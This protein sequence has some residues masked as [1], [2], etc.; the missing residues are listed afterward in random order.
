M[1]PKGLYLMAAVAL[2]GCSEMEEPI[3][4]D[5]DVPMKSVTLSANLD[6]TEPTK[7]SLDNTGLFAWQAG[8][9]ISVLSTDNKFYVFEI[10]DGAGTKTASFTGQIPETAEVSNVA[11]YPAIVSTGTDNVIISGNK[12]TFTMPETYEYVDDNTNV[13]MVANGDFVRS[14]MSFKQIGGAMRFP[15]NN[16]PRKAKFIFTSANKRITGDYSL[17]LSKIGESFIEC[18]DSAEGSSLTIN[19]SSEIDGKPASFNVPLPVGIYDDFTVSIQDESGKSLFSKEYRSDKNKIERKT[20]RLMKELQLDAIPVSVETVYPYFINARVLWHPQ[21]GAEGYALYVDDNE[22]IILP[23]LQVNSNGLMEYSFGNFEHGTEHNI[24]IAKI[25]GDGI[26]EKTKSARNAFKTGEIW[27]IRNNVGPTHICFEYTNIAGT[28]GSATSAYHVQVFDTEDTLKTPV[29]SFYTADL[30]VKKAGVY[31]GRQWYGKVN[32]NAS[33][34]PMRISVGNLQPGKDYYIRMKSVGSSEHKVSVGT[35]EGNTQKAITLYSKTGESKYSKLYKI[36]TE[37]SHSAETNEVLFEG[38]DDMALG[39]DYVNSSATLIPVMQAADK[40]YIA[41]LKKNY[42]AFLKNENKKWCV[43]TAQFNETG[44]FENYGF[45]S[46]GTITHEC[47]IKDWTYTGTCTPNYGFVVLGRNDIASLRTPALESA[48]LSETPVPCVVTLKACPVQYGPEAIFDNIRI[49]V[50]K[51]DASGNYIAASIGDTK[52]LTD[53]REYWYDTKNYKN[54]YSWQEISDVV[55]LAKGWKLQITIPNPSNGSNATLTGCIAIDDIH[56]VT[57]INLPPVSDSREESVADHTNYYS[58]G[59][60]FFPISYWWDVPAA[61][62]SKERYEEVKEA[63][64]NVVLHTGEI[65]RSFEANKQI[66]SWCQELGMK[67]I[68]Y[69]LGE[70]AA[71]RIQNT[72]ELKELYPDTYV[73]DYGWDE[74][75]SSLAAGINSFV[76]EYQSAMSDCQVY[77]NLFPSYARPYQTGVSDYSTYIDRFLSSGS[78]KSISVDTYPL[79]KNGG[80]RRDYFYNLDIVRAKALEKKI[81]FWVITQS[82]ASNDKKVTEPMIRWTVWV[83]LAFGSKGIAYFTYWQPI[84]YDNYKYMIA[85]DGTRNETYNWIKQMNSDVITIGKALMNCHADGVITTS[86]DYTLYERRFAYGPVSSVSA[87]S[88]A[89]VGCFTDVTTGA[90][91]VLVVNE[92]P[93]TESNTVSLSLDNTVPSVKITRNNETSV[94]SPS[95]GNL[96][97]SVSQGEGVLIEF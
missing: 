56:V 4:H 68:G 3:I 50:Y 87:T 85:R 58:Y 13:P 75:N 60:D 16:L 82:A 6:V 93:T 84:G 86:Y 44:T 59:D 39:T 55:M 21:Y 79:K 47:S 28:T 78:Y 52:K 66:T 27:Q 46:N 2:F 77:V 32:D 83:D 90:K 19:Y 24:A 63:G 67:Y 5:S 92:L 89:I 15:V 34:I 11:T 22:P 35:D 33:R 42:E 71:E 29:Y 41:S 65:D 36:T 8:D 9:K 38:F 45:A 81:P 37:Q 49:D 48:S 61:F 17:D 26:D 20:L 43:C 53:N 88:G 76:S 94:E 1:S 95:D 12:I 70:T 10:T 74:P 69:G 31:A 80:I 18:E 57:D 25:A 54:N 23:D 14:G 97:L 73:G 62:A 96:S 51:P 40:Q 64:F 7:A 91:K 30:N 72:K